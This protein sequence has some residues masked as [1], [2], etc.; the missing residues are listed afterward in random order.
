MDTLPYLKRSSSAPLVY[1]TPEFWLWVRLDEIYDALADLR[2]MGVRYRGS[3]AVVAL[4]IHQLNLAREAHKQLASAR[5]TTCDPELL[6]V[7]DKAYERA[8][9]FFAADVETWAREERVPDVLDSPEIPRAPPM[10]KMRHLGFYR[11]DTEVFKGDS[12]SDLAYPS[13]HAYDSQYHWMEPYLP[14]LHHLSPRDVRH[15]RDVIGYSERVAHHLLSVMNTH[16]ATRDSSIQRVCVQEWHRYTARLRGALA[17]AEPPRPP[18]PPPQSRSDATVSVAGRA[19]TVV[20]V[21][22]LGGHQ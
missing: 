8:I 1:N 19:A 12:S 2:A 20:V 15:L 16:R 13:F 5:G 9:G 21:D 6:E 10:F 14:Y 11:A 18:Q 3:R 22:E 7:V 17:K 4:Y